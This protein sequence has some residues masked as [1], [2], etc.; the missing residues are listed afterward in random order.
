VS[1]FQPQIVALC[2][3]HCAYNAAD[4]AGSLRLQYPP[5]VKIVEVPCAGR[6]DV[7][8]LLRAF[9]DGIDGALVAG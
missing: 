9:E 2:C 3:T 1:D 8:H 7:L 4:L 5:S 6:V